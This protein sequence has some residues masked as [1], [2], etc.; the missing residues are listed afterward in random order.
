V[1]DLG[2]VLRQ[3]QVDSVILALPSPSLSR[4]LLGDIREVCDREAV[5]LRI[6]PDLF[7]LSLSRSPVDVEDFRGIPVMGLRE[8]TIG[9]FNLTVKRAVDILLAGSVLALF[10]WLWALIALGVRLDSSGPIYFTQTRLGKG[11]RPFTAYKFRSMRTDAELLL[12]ELQA[13]NQTNGPTFKMRDDPRVTRVGKWLRRTSLDELPQLWNVLH[14]EMSLVGPRPPLPSEADQ[15][16][17]W[18]RRRLAVAPGMTGLWQV[19]GRSELPFD[20][21]VLLDLYYIENWSLGLDF[22]ILLRTIPAVLSG[23]GAY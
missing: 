7:E 10:S 9:G 18:H 17:E 13:H 12:A 2:D 11:G 6:V 1:S 14:G 15:Y 20:E 21:M 3:I 22:Q 16:Q 8:S 19:S 5:T 4:E 23:R